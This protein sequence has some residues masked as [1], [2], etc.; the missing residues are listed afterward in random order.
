MSNKTQ[1]IILLLAA[2]VVLVSDRFNT[3]F[4]VLFA[5]GVLVIM[6]VWGFVKDSRFRGNG[7]ED[8]L[9][10]EGKEKQP[11]NPEQIKIKQ[12]HLQKVM[13]MAAANNQI[14][15]D[16][17]QF[18]LGVSDKTAERYLQELVAQGKLTQVG[19]TGRRVFYQAKQ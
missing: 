4:A 7:N 12:E 8:G 18:A 1:G 11:I 9:E 17:V 15:N 2:I 10:V 5:A 13:E 16:D 14:T 6:A 3:N 19:E